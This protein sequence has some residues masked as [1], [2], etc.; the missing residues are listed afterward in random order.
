MKKLKL[1][2]FAIIASILFVPALSVS[3]DEEKSASTFE[4]FK[5]YVNSA[6][7]GDVIKLTQSITNAEALTIKKS[8]TQF[9]NSFL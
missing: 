9:F 3:A 7:D 4:N 2:I 5:S 1:M 8:I 6:T